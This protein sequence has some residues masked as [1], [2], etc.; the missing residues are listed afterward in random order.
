MKMKCNEKNYKM[1][2]NYQFF[3]ASSYFIKLK[4]KRGAPFKVITFTDS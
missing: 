2:N 1:R 3:A 4:T